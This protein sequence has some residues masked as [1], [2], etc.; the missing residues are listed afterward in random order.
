MIASASPQLGWLAPQAAPVAPPVA[1]TAPEVV[2]PTA[3]T[4]LD[5]QR[6]VFGLASVH[7]SI[8]QLTARLAGDQRQMAGNIAKLQADE[9]EI[10]HKLSATP[11][12]PAA[13]SAPKPTPMTPP[14]LPSTQAR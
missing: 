9:Q 4:S 2:A 3:A 7:Q 5:L 8:D 13:A 1:Q 12:R 14:L 11:P 6:L 10:L